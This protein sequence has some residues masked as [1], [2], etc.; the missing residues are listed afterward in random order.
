[1]INIRLYYDGIN[2]ILCVFEFRIVLSTENVI[3]SVHSING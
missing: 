1:M 2:R 3:I